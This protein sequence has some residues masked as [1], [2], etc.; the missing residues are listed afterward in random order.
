MV[1]LQPWAPSPSNLLPS[2]TSTPSL[3]SQAEAR[4]SARYVETLLDRSKG[5]AIV[6]Y[7]QP[8]PATSAGILDAPNNAGCEKVEYAFDATTANNSW[9]NIAGAL[10]PHGSVS[11]VLFDWQGKGLPAT[12]KIIQTHVGVVHGE[13]PGFEG[14]TGKRQVLGAKEFAFAWYGLLGR[15]LR[16]SVRGGA[17]WS[18]KCRA[19]VDGLEGW[20]G[21]RE[22]VYFKNWRNRRALRGEI[23]GPM[24]MKG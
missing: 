2:Q 20:E 6:D 23:M 16:A 15:G 3:P 19:S 7:R 1:T 5:D 4:V 10:D 12:L 24:I 22:K 13:G 17:G 14:V 21:E 18:G 8:D 9:A 11:L